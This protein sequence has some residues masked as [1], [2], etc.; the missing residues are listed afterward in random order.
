M[1]NYKTGAQRYND[2]MG[3]IFDHARSEGR[4]LVSDS[5]LKKRPMGN[6]LI[7]AEE[8][9]NPAYK[10]YVAASKSKALNK[11]KSED[12]MRH[13]RLQ[14]IKNVTPSLGNNNN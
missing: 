2:R 5:G 8:K 13:L 4:G 10:K 11:A 12:E 14:K 3:K 1:A 6:G 7:T 9:K